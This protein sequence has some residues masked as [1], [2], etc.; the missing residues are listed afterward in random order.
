MG[1]E[2]Q[3]EEQEEREGE[4]QA[5]THPTH[6]S[7]AIGFSRPAA[8][9]LSMGVPPLGSSAHDASPPNPSLDAAPDPSD[10]LHRGFLDRR[11]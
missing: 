1:N 8:S 2:L 11:P 3:T 10:D 6:P 9:A 5:E 7:E 4:G